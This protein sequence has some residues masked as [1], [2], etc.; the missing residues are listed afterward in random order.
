V[1]LGGDG[2]G[3]TVLWNSVVRLFGAMGEVRSK[4]V[5]ESYST[6]V[7]GRAE[8]CWSRKR[9]S[10]R[11]DPHGKCRPSKIMNYSW[12][13]SLAVVRELWV[14]FVIFW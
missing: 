10:T 11:I 4:I 8:V 5:A 1:F 7:V 9:R 13:A 6:G 2:N 12:A 3:G 14:E